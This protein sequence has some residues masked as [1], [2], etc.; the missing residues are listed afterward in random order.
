VI[1]PE[2][3]PH[4]V[5]VCRAIAKK[6]SRVALIGANGIGKDALCAWLVE[7]F[8]YCFQGLVPITSAS[9]R[10]VRILWREIHE[11]TGQS[12]ARSSFNL[13]QQR[14][15]VI[16]RR[17][18]EKAYSEG[19]KA[20]SEQKIEGYHN[21]VMLY[22]MTEA[23]GCEDWAYRAMLKACSQEDNR[24]LI[25]SVPGLEEG[26]FF[27]I[28]QGAR[29]RWEVITIPAAK[30]IAGPGGPKYVPTTRLVSQDSIDEKLE[31]GE[32]SQWFV[33]PV[34]AQF[35]KAGSL[36][37]ITLGDFQ[38]AVERSEES[39]TSGGQDILG[40]DVA[41]VGRNET[42]FCHR[43]GAHVVNFISYSQERT[44]ET[45]KICL[46]WLGSHPQGMMVIEHVG[47]G[48]GV[49][50][51]VIAAGFED[52]MVEINPGGPPIEKDR[53]KDRR[54]ELYFYLAK[55]FET[56]EISIPERYE[57]SPLSPQLT[58]LRKIVRGDQIF[59][60][61]SKRIA[62]K[63]MPSPDWADALMLTLA[64]SDTHIMESDTDIWAGGKLTEPDW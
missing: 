51:H 8:L 12:K 58:S 10:Q 47:V 26:E 21:P 64:V 4:Q 42:V 57:H 43:K 9:A 6:N 60:L 48:A 32:N 34:L 63:R 46:Q 18:G 33:G 41:W 20:V 24:I 53:F 29:S 50:D 36:S 40:V 22:I 27:R 7:W 39:E 55:K 56:G 45:E 30:K 52:R 49:I 17:E 37:L 3:E 28:A 35:I 54:S 16:S 1:G 14:M 5:K 11:W 44:T 13:L 2:P 61:E 23:R 38:N 15:E 31:Y 62:A 25:Q 59:E 19:F